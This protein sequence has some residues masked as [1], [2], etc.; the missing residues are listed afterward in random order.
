MAWSELTGQRKR[1]SRTYQQGDQ[2]HW[3]GGLA[4]L[5]YESS[6]DSGNY[7]TPINTTPVRVNN[8]VFD[9]WR[10]TA[11]G[12]HYAIGRDLANHGSE[13]GWIGF[14]GRQGAHSFKFRLL[15]AGYLH[16]PTRAWDD[17]GGAPSYTRANLARQTNTRTVGPSGIDTLNVEAL[18]AWDNL[19]TTPGSGSLS[20]RWRVSGDYLKE[21][22]VINQAARTWIAANRAPSTPASETYFGFVFRLDWSDIPK[23]LRDGVLQDTEDDFADDDI[24][25]ELKDA[26]DRL[27][28]FMPIDD[29]F[30]D[31]GPT[32]HKQPLRK[33]FYK[34]SDGNHY[35]LVGCRV[36]QLNSLPAGD[37]VFDPTVNEQVGADTDDGTE[38][39]DTTWFQGG[40]QFGDNNVGEGEGGA[41]NLFHTGHRFQTV[42]I[43]QGSTVS[44]ATYTVVSR[45]LNQAGTVNS[46]VYCEAIDDAAVFSS[47]ARVSTRTPTAGVAWDFSAFTAGNQTLSIITPVQAVF[48]R[49]GWVANNDL[50]VLWKGDAGT[51]SDVYAR[52]YDYAD[53]AAN[54]AKLDITYTAP[55]ATI[56]RQMMAHHGG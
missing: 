30:V 13:D 34:D 31:V 43:V 17:I 52:T 37:L 19:W 56:L 32:R 55:A 51:G 29:V 26:S 46:D 27:L 50:A 35:L 38:D 53:S 2:F 45:G 7:D 8:A 9:G 22:I 5:H 21:E 1:H 20:V 49:A 33:R 47:T 54:A 39:S 4:P 36:D 42:N 12:W 28:A 14:G 40:N 18:A 44:V 15:R 16:W 6:L 41:S 3:S 10:I 23:V 25:I 48:N 24:S 11:N